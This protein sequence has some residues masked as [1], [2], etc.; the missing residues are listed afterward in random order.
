MAHLKFDMA[1]LERL[2]DPARFEQ[3]PPEVFWEALGAPEGEVTIVEIGAGTGL[4]AQAF[5]QRAHEAVV[6]AADTA[7]E[8]LEWMRV[9]RPE[10]AQERIVPVKASEAGLPLPDDVADALYMVNLHHELAEPEA[11]YAEAL[12]LLKPG[13]PLLVVDWAPRETPKGPPLEI[14]VQPEVL[15]QLLAETGFADVRVDADRLPWHTMAT[16]RK[17][18]A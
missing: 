1:K 8:M 3:L 11:S 9:N 15:E 5:T 10:V 2:N 7:D 12:R 17:P 4:F 18:Q 16:A 14:R 6:Y 13:A